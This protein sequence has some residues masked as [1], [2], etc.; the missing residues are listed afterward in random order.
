MKD[1]EKEIIERN[2]S[3]YEELLDASKEDLAF[4]I[5]QLQEWLKE[6][7]KKS[8]KYKPLFKNKDSSIQFYHLLRKH[9]LITVDLSTWKKATIDAPKF[10]IEH[11]LKERTVMFTGPPTVDFI[12]SKGLLYSLL[13]K[14]YKKHIVYTWAR[15]VKIIFTINGK[16]DRNAS[17]S[18]SQWN[19]TSELSKE[20]KI[21]F[22]EIIAD[23]CD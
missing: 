3:Q 2:R 19:P 18:K 5:I 12:G 4:Y 8:Y 11:D 23:M 9:N 16:K 21:L 17:Q 14:L 20:D 13:Q 15:H 6:A 1:W 7:E 22:S 10:N